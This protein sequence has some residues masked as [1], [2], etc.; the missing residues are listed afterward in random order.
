MRN[1]KSPEEIG[2]LRLVG[3]I[4]AMGDSEAIRYAL[5]GMYQYQLEAR[6]TFNF[7]DHGAQAPIVHPLP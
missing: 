5:P 3:Q 7:L 1:I 2:I 4:S 6:A